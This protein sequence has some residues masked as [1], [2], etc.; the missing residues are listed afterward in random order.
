MFQNCHKY[1]YSH[2]QQQPVTSINRPL[3]LLAA[4]PVCRHGCIKIISVNLK[5]CTYAMRIMS[6]RRYPICNIQMVKQVLLQKKGP[7][8]VTFKLFQI[9]GIFFLIVSSKPHAK[10]RLVTSQVKKFG[11]VRKS[12]YDFV[13][14]LH[15]FEDIGN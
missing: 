11:T 2:Q 9:K 1:T 10:N 12:V 5:C 4:W 14:N 8:T 3:L 6:L 13:A 15:H 7:F